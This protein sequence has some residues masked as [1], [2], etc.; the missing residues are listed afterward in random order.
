MACIAEVTDDHLPS[1]WRLLRPSF[2][3]GVLQQPRSLGCRLTTSLL[4]C[5]SRQA[6]DSG[7]ARVGVHVGYKEGEKKWKCALAAAA[8]TNDD[9]HQE[10]NKDGMALLPLQGHAPQ[11]GNHEKEKEA[12]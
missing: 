6:F 3:F 4:L 11:G 10:E 9:D 8:A 2:F 5:Q 1:M 7:T 12:S